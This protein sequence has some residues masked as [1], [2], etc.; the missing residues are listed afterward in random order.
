V[1]VREGLRVG[2]GEEGADGGGQGAEGGGAAGR[3]GGGR[4][5][6]SMRLLTFDWTIFTLNPCCS[7]ASAMM[8]HS[9]PASMIVKSATSPLSTAMAGR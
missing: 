4:G 7:S 6:R 9:L 1:W 8:F 5:H 3:E 2:E